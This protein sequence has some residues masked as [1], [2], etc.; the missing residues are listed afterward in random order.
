MKV[1]KKL[2]CLLL[3]LVMVIS[4]IPAAFADNEKAG[5]TCPDC[6]ADESVKDKGTL[7]W[8]FDSESKT[9][10][11]V[12]SKDEKHVFQSGPC[13]PKYESL[14]NGKHK[15]VC[16]VCGQELSASEDC[17]FGNW[18]NDS[19]K[20]TH[21]KTCAKCGYKVAENCNVETWKA[22]SASGNTYTH[23]GT[24]TI[25]NGTVEKDCEI[26]WGHDVVE[27]Y[28][29]AACKTCGRRD[30][31]ACAVNSEGWKRV[32]NQA[33]HTGTCKNWNHS[34]TEACDTLGEG[35][36]CSKCG[37]TKQIT[38]TIDKVEQAQ[39]VKVTKTEADKIKNEL[40]AMGIK[41]KG[42]YVLDGHTA[43]VDCPVTWT[44]VNLTTNTAT[45]T[46]T[47]PAD[48]EFAHYELAD[49]AKTTT[50]K[51][52][53]T[54][55]PVFTASMNAGHA[56]ANLNDSRTLSVT[57]D[58]ATAPEGFS[59]Y[60][61]WTVKKDNGTAESFAK[62]TDKKNTSYQFKTAGTYVFTCKI[63]CWN[64]DKTL[65][66]ERT[67]ESLAITV[68]GVFQ[69]TLTPEKKS[70]VSSYTYNVGDQITINAELK[71]KNSSGIYV[72]ATTS[73]YSYVDWTL[74]PASGMSS[75]ELA[76]NAEISSSYTYHSSSLKRVVN[77]LAAGTSTSGLSFQLKA[78][79]KDASGN[80]LIT[81]STVSMSIKPAAI[82]SKDDVSYEINGDGV[83]FD[84]DDFKAA[85]TATFGKN[86]FVDSL[87]Y[88]YFAKPTN[89]TIYTSTSYTTSSYVLSDKTRCYVSY[90]SGSVTELD[91]LYFRPTKTGVGGSATYT[92]Y[93]SDGNV[94]AT[95]KVTIGSETGEIK[96]F[97]SSGGSVTFDEGDFKKFVDDYYSKSN[98]NLR[99]VTFDMDKVTYSKSG[100]STRY[101]SLYVSSSRSA[102][103]ITSRRDYK[104][105]YGYS[106]SSNRGAY[107]IDLDEVTFKTGTSTDTYTVK[108]PFKAYY[109]R[110]SSGTPGTDDYVA[111]TVVV[112]V[113]D[114]KTIGMVGV[115]FD[116]IDAA[117]LVKDAFDED[118]EYVMFTL[119]LSTEGTLYYNFS[120]IV[121]TNYGHLV[122]TRNGYYL[123]SGKSS[124]Y[125]LENIYFLPA[126]D[127]P[128][129]I[130][131]SYVAYDKNDKVLT[132]NKG[133]GTIVLKVGKKNAS[134]YFADVTST[135]ASWA[136][137][138]VDFLYYFNMSKGGGKNASGRTV[139]KYN[140]NMTRA[141]L[142][143]MLYRFVGEPSVAGYTNSFTDVK[144]KSAY[145]YNAVLWASHE[146]VVKGTGNKFN[147]SGK[148]TR[149]QI[150]AIL[151][152]YGGQKSSSKSL[153]S[154]TDYS[155]V[156]TYAE[157]AMRWAVE[158]GYVKG[159]NGYLN[160]QGNA[161]RAE[162]AVMLHRFLTRL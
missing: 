31:V 29:L 161:T 94:I 152:R 68:G 115:D 98:A 109:A 24:C 9:H 88:V 91:N 25:C 26:I 61:E 74:V 65:K 104:A 142:V 124:N 37:T 96:Y 30:S 90:R 84:A 71:K 14:K 34:L 108:I 6:A 136:A 131:L 159:A 128:D 82:A 27:G 75:S 78:T 11:L 49:G 105:Y 63:T 10:K 132:E 39:P 8:K 7:S 138:A 62:G 147:P 41:V 158:N 121:A 19:G 89:G 119:P 99:Y 135:Q 23:S 85:I 111:G 46:V 154:F 1:F 66:S 160:P 20:N 146:G 22:D 28:D 130:T 148:V 123:K 56:T 69:L 137:D 156:S 162:V 153:Y 145:Y 133:K 17:S 83:S 16:S 97:T 100:S 117:D 51:F 35:G 2:T 73:D 3:V 47:A 80:T 101:G 52:N 43:T 112:E 67:V 134:S 21:T 33:K 36:K 139:F 53:K 4:M 127:C 125:E 110:T 93:N 60:Y 38:Y 50:I 150:A 141:E 126:A 95:G 157:T 118:V 79:V 92:A 129:T 113:N 40:N 42:N 155:K 70:G 54:T 64:D 59:Y 15:S 122:S 107:D 151:W 76:K 103:E 44:Y 72:P 144:D 13:T 55:A 58:P 102:D 149:E 32:P 114:A 18:V 77:A 45:G 116:E 86:S 120:S 81:N 143:T 87:D 5:E 106:A 57:T 140:D 48:T 12:C